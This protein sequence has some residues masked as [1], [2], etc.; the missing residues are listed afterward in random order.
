[1][2]DDIPAENRQAEKTA[3]RAVKI[4]LRSKLPGAEAALAA[5]SAASHAVQLLGDV[6]G[7]TVSLYM[8]IRGELDPT[9]LAPVLR[10]LG[11]AIALPR[12]T[13][14]EEPM[15]FRAWAPEDRLHKGFGGILEPAETAPEAVPDIVIVP[16][17]AFDRRGFRIGYGKGHFDRTL[18]PLAR[19]RRPFLVG[20]AF[21]L[22][23]VDEVPRELHD[24]PLDAVVTE[25][26]IIHCN[27]ARDGV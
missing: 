21:A 26:E 25:T 8:P 14:E 18:G 23:E 3:V 17:A 4:A 20:Y 27:P 15:A 7:K 10:S 2:T 12:V 22:Q 6:T 16:L 19:G 13:A 11:A 1:M 5:Q 24:V 9:P